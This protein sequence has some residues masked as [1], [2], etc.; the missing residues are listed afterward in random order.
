MEVGLVHGG[1]ADDTK[2]GSLQEG[3]V[4]SYSKAVVSERKTLL[5]GG[6]AEVVDVDAS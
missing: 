4:G 2:K 3:V 1:S 5:T 6:K